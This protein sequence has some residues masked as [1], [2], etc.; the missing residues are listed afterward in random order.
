MLDMGFINDVRKI[1]DLLPKQRQTLLFS[2]TMPAEIRSLAEK[3]LV[4]PHQVQVAAQSATA[5]NIDQSVYFVSRNDKPALLRHLLTMDTADR[6]LVFT[7]TKHGADKV[8]HR[9]CQAGIDA[10]SIHGNK[11][12]NARRRS[13]ERFKEGGARVLVATDIAS[14]GIDIDSISHVVNYELPD[15]PETYVH[16]IGRTARA[17][18][19]GVSVSFCDNEERS[20]LRDIERLIRTRIKVLETPDMTMSEEDRAAE[21]KAQADYGRT[22]ERPAERYAERR[23]GGGARSSGGFR[24]QSPPARE[25]SAGMGGQGRPFRERSGGQSGGQERPGNNSDGNRRFGSGLNRNRPPRRRP[26]F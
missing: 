24:R 23:F 26:R 1:S 8:A 18:A 20:N 17:G 15:V 9:L 7:R 2:A 5:D 21:R 11:T 19:S 25:R 16:R 22:R 4:N 10:E 6:V 14:R 3:L 13:L 12:Q